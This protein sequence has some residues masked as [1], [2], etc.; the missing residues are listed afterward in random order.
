MLRRGRTA[1]DDVVSGAE[2]PPDETAEGY[3]AQPENA[4]D[5]PRRSAPPRRHMGELG[6][7]G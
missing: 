4:N 6:G 3:P 1:I 5:P 7:V 2:N